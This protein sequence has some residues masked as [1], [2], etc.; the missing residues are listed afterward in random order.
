MPDAPQRTE[1]Y[2]HGH[3]A[4]VLRAHSWRTVDNSAAY[5]A[6]HLRPGLDVLDVGSGPGTITVDIGRR[7]APGRVVGLD[8]AADVVGQATAL[9]ESEGL[10]NVEFTSG[11]AYALDFPD[12]SFDIVHAHQVL[13]HLGDPVA[14]LREMRRVTRPGG[15]VAARDVIY[16]SASWYPLLPGLAEWMRIY[17]GVAHSNGGDPNAGRALKALAHEAGFSDVTSTASIWCFSGREDREWWGGA[18]AERA[19]ASSF[20]PQ[21]IE[22]GVA[23]LADLQAVSDAWTAWVD[24]D[25]AWFSMPHGEIIARV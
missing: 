7:V 22:A 10:R 9:A 2:T 13:Q 18:W 17:Q 11:D 5:L 8:A 14:A 25:D 16:L 6:P 4:S 19:V 20:A 24:D 3:H 1:R 21:S 12:D 15:I 23:T